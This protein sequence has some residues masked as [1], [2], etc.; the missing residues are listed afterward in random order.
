[1]RTK[2]APLVHLKTNNKLTGSV[3]SVLGLRKWSSRG[4]EIAGLLY[5]PGDIRLALRASAV[6]V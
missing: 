6:I 1:M 2:P 5:R 3:V 4:R